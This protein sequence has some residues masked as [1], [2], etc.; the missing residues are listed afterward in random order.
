M[1]GLVFLHAFP[2]NPRMWEEE[3]GYFR[4]RLPV[5]APTTW[6]LAWGRPRKRS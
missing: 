3:V 4:G 2:Y 1:Q 5:L 6:G